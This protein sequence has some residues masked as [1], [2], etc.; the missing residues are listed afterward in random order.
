MTLTEGTPIL[1]SSPNLFGFGRK[2][3]PERTNFKCLVLVKAAKGQ[4]MGKLNVQKQFL[5]IKSKEGVFQHKFWG[6]ISSDNYRKERKGK[7]SSS[8][9]HSRTLMEVML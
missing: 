4:N 2:H 3:T 6:E 9:K 7:L 5:T 8:K 1:R